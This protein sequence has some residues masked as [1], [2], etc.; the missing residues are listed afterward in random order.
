[1]LAW[2]GVLYLVPVAVVYLVVATVAA[3]ALGRRGRIA[4][5]PAI[6]GAAAAIAAALLLLA[7]YEEVVLDL[8]PA[9]T[10]DDFVLL[11]KL[12]FAGLYLAV[13]GLA[14]AA[15]RRLGGSWRAAAVSVAITVAFLAL[16]FRFVEFLNACNIGEP[17][18]W[19]S[20]IEC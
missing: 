1:M 3:A 8:R 9:P 12:A 5:W 10:R 13:V 19:P 14:L 6:A 2:T 16:T 11:A 4:P 17:V 18:L 7:A 15:G 20:Y